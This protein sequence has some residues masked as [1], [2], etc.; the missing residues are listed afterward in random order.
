ML[1]ENIIPDP[2]SPGTIMVVDDKPSNLRLLEKMLGEDGYRV[3]IFTKGET[4]LKSAIND[5]PDLIL[6]DI[7]MPKMSGYEVCRRLKAEKET[8]DLPVIFI[9]ALSETI[10]KVKAFK[11]GGVDYITKPFQ[12]EEV[13]ARISLHL[14]LRHTEKALEE[15]NQ[16]LRKTLDNLK[17]AQTRLIQSEKMAAL[18]VLVAG[19]AHEINNPVNFIKTSILGL[20]QDLEDLE[21][22]LSACEE[23]SA[24]CREKSAGDHLQDIKAMIDYTTLKVEIPQLVGN[25]RQ[26]V[27]RT[28]EIIDS[29]RSYSR[30]D[31]IDTEETDLC[32][33]IDT[34]LVILR[35][36]YKD[37]ISIV[38]NFTELPRAKVH[39][40]K[41]TQVLINIIS[42][43]IDAVES[44][45]PR[46]NGTITIGTGI[47]SR[48]GNRYAVISIGDN[49]PGIPAKVQGNIFDPFFT[50]K[51]VGSGTGLGL[52]I[53]IG[54]IKKHHGLIKVG[55]AMDSGTT[56]SIFL[57]LTPV[58][59][60]QRS[61]NEEFI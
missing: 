30:M 48:A 58:T 57:P 21:K 31:K 18:G 44:E 33:L 41:V 49:G 34:A 54:I 2:V 27:D 13:Q 37:N 59:E 55:T 22:L 60:V 36:R 40:G 12:I 16:E 1:K 26:G 53:S 29:L 45:Q 28:E 47:Q 15:K 24:N 9:S 56:F 38:K 4:A 23:C 50:T 42:N 10:D 11:L 39:P 20:A 19:I 51:E 7:N 3:R 52:S 43:A 14:T 5:P 32:G 35:N 6:L 46:K 25:I 61:L 17:N 8:K